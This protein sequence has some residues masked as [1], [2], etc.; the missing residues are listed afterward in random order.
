L[1]YQYPD[2]LKAKP[3]LWLWELK[4]ITVLGMALLLSVLAFSQ[5]RTPVLLAITA[6]GAFL[7]IRVDDITILDYIRNCINFFITKQQ[8]YYWR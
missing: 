3:T 1:N 7:T 4:H 5:L 8:I 6:V 2:N